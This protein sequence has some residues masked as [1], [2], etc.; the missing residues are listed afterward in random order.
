MALPW[1]VLE[2]LELLEGRWGNL[3]ESSCARSRTSEASALMLA[4]PERCGRVATLCYFP[5]FSASF[6]VPRTLGTF[7]ISLEHTRSW[8]RVS[9][10]CSLHWE[11]RLAKRRC[12]AV[13]LGHPKWFQFAFIMT[14]HDISWHNH[15][16]IMT[17]HDTKGQ[18]GVSTRHHPRR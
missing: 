15:D 11:D 16:I 5:I 4:I 14:Y 9:S 1:H 12:P 7:R 18:A 8:P 2:L 17:Y 10:S 3:P 6:A 13:L